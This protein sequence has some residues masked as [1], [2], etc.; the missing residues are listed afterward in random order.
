LCEHAGGA[1]SS[2]HYTLR[3]LPTMRKPHDPAHLRAL[4]GWPG[5]LG[6]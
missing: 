6:R 2:R 4:A 1:A 5:W 3:A